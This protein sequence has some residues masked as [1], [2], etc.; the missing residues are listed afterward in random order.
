MLI[1]LCY[2]HRLSVFTWSGEDVS[3]TLRVDAYFLENGEKI[4]VFE[5]IRY[6]WIGP[7]SFQ[8]ASNERG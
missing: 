6:V 2:F 1:S 4:S 8:F 3:N 5:N 7:K